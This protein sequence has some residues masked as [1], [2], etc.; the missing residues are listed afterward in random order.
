M[1]NIASWSFFLYLFQTM[2]QQRDIWPCP[3]LITGSQYFS[4][5]SFFFLSRLSSEN[6]GHVH[7][8]VG[9]GMSIPIRQTFCA[10]FFHW[11]FL[12]MCEKISSKNILCCVRRMADDALWI[13][14]LSLSIRLNAGMVP[15]INRRPL[16]FSLSHGWNK[17]NQP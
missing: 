15:W 17:V 10:W 2:W 4:W 11:E 6:E 16:P 13:S 7:I 3:Q 8:K 9:T 12:I 14:W 1:S 5:S